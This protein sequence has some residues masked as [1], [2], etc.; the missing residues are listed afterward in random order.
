MIKRL[1]MIDWSGW[2]SDSLSSIHSAMNSGGLFMRQLLCRPSL[3]LL[4]IGR[5]LCLVIA[6]MG[7][8]ILVLPALGS[9]PNDQ[10]RIQYRDLIDDSVIGHSGTPAAAVLNMLDGVIPDNLERNLALESLRNTARDLAS[11]LEEAKKTRDSAVTERTRA[12]HEHLQAILEDDAALDREI[13]RF[14]AEHRDAIDAHRKKLDYWLLPYIADIEPLCEPAAVVLN[15]VLARVHPESFA[16]N[17]VELA[18]FFPAGHAE[19]AWADLV[20]SR[21][22]VVYTDGASYCRVFLPGPDA[23]SAWSTAYP[24]ARHILL[25]LLDDTPGSRLEVDVFAYENDIAKTTL[26]LHPSGLTLAPSA[27]DL[28]I[29]KGR[30]PIDLGSLSRFFDARLALEGCGVDAEGNL[31]LIGSPCDVAPTLDGHPISLSDFAVAYRASAYSGHAEA[32]MSLD[33]SPDPE[34]VNVNFG[35]RL[36]DTRLGWVAYLCDLRFKTIADDFDP[37][38]FENLAPVIRERIPSF[39]SQQSRMFASPRFGEIVSE[40]TRFWFYPDEFRIVVSGDNTACLVTRPRFTAAA[41]RQGAVDKSG[42]RMDDQAPTWTLDALQHV[43]DN[44]D[45]YASLF[46]ELRELDHAGA[47]LGYY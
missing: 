38:S 47:P 1:Q 3:A 6:I 45:Q 33:P 25:S 23:L 46:G 24:V 32:Y 16:D 12:Q 37:V 13:V 29:P 11:A 28:G 17:L 27:A 39:L 31:I 8:V 20:R 42:E 15:D 35:G 22:F 44:Y 7:Q 18:A 21:R 26:I 2:V 9:A 43:N 4:Q 34:F 40:S 19:P 10:V 36:H 41:E 30:R 14:L 5:S